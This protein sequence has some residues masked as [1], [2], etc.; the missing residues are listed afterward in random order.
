[1]RVG[2]RGS[3]PARRR[4]RLIAVLLLCS[5][6][7]GAAASA[8]T[9]VEGSPRAPAPV[10][11]MRIGGVFCACHLSVYVAWKQGFLERRGVRVTG[12]EFTAGGSRT[13]AGVAPGRLDAGAATVET[14]VR[15]RTA[16]PRVVAI[17]NLYPEPWA[18]SVRRDERSSIRRPRDLRGRTVGVSSIGSGS[19]AFL[20]ALLGRSGLGAGDVRIVELGGLDQIL[21]AL[22]TGRVDAAVTWEPGTSAAAL[23]RSAAPIVN[24]LDRSTARRF[25][26]SRVSMSQVLAVRADL[27]RGRPRLA[28]A[29]VA[30]L[31]D[32]DRWLRRH[33]PARAARV[34]RRIAPRSI[35]S[36]SLVAAARATMRIQPR[37]PR[38]TRRGYR[39][40]TRLL[41]QTG[42]LERPAAFADVVDCRFAGCGR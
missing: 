2:I 30:A 20:V 37:S 1:M 32:A 13:Y 38:L 24:L 25:F 40:S 27:A 10:G 12:F 35:S 26:G 8:A 4:I 17:A 22:R 28:R 42:A 34:L 9:G 6:A 11:A 3:I 41:L 7:A 15:G 5:A 31:A 23:S 16:G 29:L 39:T 36:A 21:S 33:S 18:L 14:L 19:W